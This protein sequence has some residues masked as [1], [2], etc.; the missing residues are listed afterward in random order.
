MFLKK[1][2]LKSN[3]ILISSFLIIFFYYLNYPLVSAKGVVLGIG[4]ES[5]LKNTYIIWGLLNDYIYSFFNYFFG[6]FISD[7]NLWEL[8]IAFQVSVLWSLT[9][10]KII[11]NSSI[12]S[13]LVFFNPFILNYFTLCTRDAIT[14][15]LIFLIG[16]K[17]WDM[18]RLFSALIISFM[19]IGLLPIYITSFLT[20]ILR[21][22]TKRFFILVSLTSILSSVLIYLLLR[23]TDII[24]LL[25]EGSYRLALEYPRLGY[26]NKREVTEMLH[27]AYNSTVSFNFKILSFGFVGQIFCIAFK[28]MFPKNTFSFCFSSFFICSVLSSIPNADRYT[29]HPILIAFPFLIS[30]SLN[31]LHIQFRKF[32]T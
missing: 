20:Y 30:F 28:N 5:G 2:N 18:I 16:F 10:R 14:L 6:S 24:N 15:S 9:I 25:P 23:Q 7:I 29:Y 3:T 12:Y 19:H 13:L 11:I 27:L 8:I 21:K 1:A 22:R 4:L 32:Y 26:T 31:T 17:G